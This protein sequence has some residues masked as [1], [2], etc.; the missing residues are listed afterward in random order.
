M[1]SRPNDPA[2]A[3]RRLKVELRNARKVA[4]RT[5]N[6]VARAMEWSNAKLIRIESG[7]AKISRNDLK[8]LLEYYGITGRER[9][10]ALH[11]MARTV[12]E[13]ESWPDYGDLFPAST[14]RFFGFESSAEIIRVFQPVVVPGLLQT[15]EYC[16]A[17]LLQAYEHYRGHVERIWE[18]RQRRHRLHDRQLPP[19]MF[20]IIDE[21][22]VRRP[23][24]GLQAMRRQLAALQEYQEQSHITI[25]IL[26]FAAGAHPGLTNRFVLLEFE[27]SNDDDLLYLEEPANEYTDDPEMT[28]KYL[29][30]FFKL[31][32]IALSPEE[33]VVF[34]DKVIAEM[35][36]AAAGA[37]PG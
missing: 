31:S 28:G 4:G 22:A 26:P 8:A 2:V 32:D 29:D 27:D 33:T 7:E 3:R 16:S 14:R 24:G 10:E 15:E 23:V 37:A 6:E 9:V 11:D 30:R 12:R 18:M 5:Q 36:E 1:S 21:A 20:F 25:Q 35:D 19:M 34:L 13:E 17:L